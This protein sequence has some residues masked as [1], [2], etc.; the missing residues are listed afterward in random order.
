MLRNKQKKL[1]KTLVIAKQIKQG[2]IVATAEQKEMVANKDALQNECKELQALIDL[3]VKSN[4]ACMQK[5]MAAMPAPVEEVK[6]EVAPVKKEVETSS[7]GL[8]VIFKLAKLPESVKG[9]PG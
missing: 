4:P 9:T 3:Y 1:D 2:E 7:E 6:V 5:E 8:V